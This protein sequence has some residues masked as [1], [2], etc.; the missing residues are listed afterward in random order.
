MST[1]RAWEG[2]PGRVTTLGPPGQGCHAAGAW[3]SCTRQ[4]RRRGTQNPPH[5]RG[6]TL[7]CKT[8]GS[9]S[10]ISRGVCRLLASGQNRSEQFSFPKG[11]REGVG[12]GTASGARAARRERGWSRSSRSA[13]E[14][15]QI[16]LQ[17]HAGRRRSIVRC[18]ARPLARGTGTRGD[19]DLPPPLP[20]TRLFERPEMHF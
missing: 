6:P 16:L 14:M 13:A 3:Q 15:G 4:R 5:S 7:T 2:P 18:P 12:G 10:R 1:A 9:L 11:E 8:P 19:S 20:L 17:Q